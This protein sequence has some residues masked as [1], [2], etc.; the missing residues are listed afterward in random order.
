M[1]IH[2]LTEQAADPGADGKPKR[3]TALLADPAGTNLDPGRRERVLRMLRANGFS[4]LSRPVARLAHARLGLGGRSDA[5]ERL[6]ACLGT[7]LGAK[8]PLTAMIQ[9][10]RLLETRAKAVVDG[11]AGTPGS[12][13]ALRVVVE[14]GVFLADLRDRS[15]ALEDAFRA[16]GWARRNPASTVWR[17]ADAGLASFCRDWMTAEARALLAEL[18]SRRKEAIAASW[19]DGQGTAIDI[20]APEGLASYPY[21]RA[22]IAFGAGLSAVLIADDMGLGKTPQAIGKWNMTPAWGWSSPSPP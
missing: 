22:G 4:R 3:L 16:A 11:L 19:D 15:P 1:R 6:Q 18:L 21:Q 9:L 8:L 7:P 17:I 10:Y 12:A 14:N 13:V 20:P 5:L 2:L